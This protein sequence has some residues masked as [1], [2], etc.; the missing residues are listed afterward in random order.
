MT[1]NRKDIY[2]S[3]KDAILLV[4]AWA[5]MNCF[6]A[7]LETP[8]LLTERSKQKEYALDI[9]KK[10]DKIVSKIPDSKLE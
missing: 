8:D 10:L 4:D 2:L 7:Y 9:Y 1:K 6:C 5:A 3:K